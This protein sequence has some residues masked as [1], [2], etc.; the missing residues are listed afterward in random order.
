MLDRAKLQDHYDE[1]DEFDYQA[2]TA[3]ELRLIMLYRRMSDS[4]RQRVIRMS[5][6]LSEVPDSSRIDNAHT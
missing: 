2:L 3:L 1:S 4:D 6:A 5:K